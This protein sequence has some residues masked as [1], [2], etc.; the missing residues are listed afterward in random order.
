MQDADPGRGA[1]CSGKCD[2]QAVGG[3]REHGQPELLGPQPVAAA[4][5]R[6]WRMTSGCSGLYRSSMA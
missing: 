3:E 2:W 1:V 5:T 6:L 4:I